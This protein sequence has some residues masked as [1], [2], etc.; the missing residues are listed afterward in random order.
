MEPSLDTLLDLSR[1]P[2]ARRTSD[3][4]REL[5]ALVVAAEPAARVRRSLRA[6]VTLSGLAAVGLMGLGA[7]ASVAGVVPSPAWAPWYDGPSNRHTQTVTP[8]GRCETT[9]GIKAI[10]DQRH[11]ATPATRE[12]AV[13]AAREFLRGFDF[14]TIDVARAVEDLPPTATHPD[15][16]PEDREATAVLLTLDERIKAHLAELGLPPTVGISMAQTCLEDDAS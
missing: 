16:D 12:A 3:L 1:P 6:R 9:Y 8:D 4:E 15:D 14:S 10:E 11:P 2:T 5:L 13:A 7:G